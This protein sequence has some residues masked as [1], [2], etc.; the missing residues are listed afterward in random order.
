MNCE[1]RRA[2]SEEQRAN[3]EEKYSGETLQGSYIA[4]VYYPDKTRVGWWKNG[5]LEYFAKVLNSTNWI[6]INVRI[7]DEELDLSICR[8]LDFK[9]VLNM[10]EG[11]LER[12]F[13]AKLNSGKIVCVKA[14]RFL[15]IVDTEIGAIRYSVIPENFNDNISFEPYLDA[16]VKNQDSN[17][18]EK[19]WDEVSRHTGSGEGY[20]MVKTKKL[21]FHK[22]RSV[23]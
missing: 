23:N 1:V 15:S 19:F 14:K 16:N 18:K 22:K 20:V 6:G 11:Y 13:R 17:Y 21:D 4:G 7:D 8:V 3:F 12:T 5:Y 9:R 2:K 10:R